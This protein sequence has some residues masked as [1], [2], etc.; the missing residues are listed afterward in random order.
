MSSKGLVNNNNNNKTV[1]SFSS[2][3]SGLGISVNETALIGFD[4]KYIFVLIATY[5]IF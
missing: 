2:V 5:F 3:C 4:R 1:G